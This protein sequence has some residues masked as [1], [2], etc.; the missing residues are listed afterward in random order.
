MDWTDEQI[1]QELPLHVEEV[2]IYPK[3]MPLDSLRFTERLGYRKE[4]A[5]QML[6]MGCYNTL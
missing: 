1:V 4:N 2:K 3:Q 5:I 6:T